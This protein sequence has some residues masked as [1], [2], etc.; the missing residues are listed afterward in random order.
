[1]SLYSTLMPGE[2]PIAIPPWL[3][4]AA[5]ELIGTA[6]KLITGEK[7]GTNRKRWV[8]A[9]L[10]KL[11]REHNVEQIPDWIEKPAEELI[12]D[13]LVE[14]VFTALRRAQS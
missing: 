10:R 1:M 6:E 14:V 3:F 13:V 8:T 9:G 5:N 11:L 12:V 4:D 7:K 2:S